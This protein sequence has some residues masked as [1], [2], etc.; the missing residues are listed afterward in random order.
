M[1]RGRRRSNQR[2]GEARVA[3]G[4]VEDGAAPVEKP[5][6]KTFEASLGSWTVHRNATC[7]R[8]EQLCAA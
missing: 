2:T 3:Y 4:N 8:L 1:K 6:E 7:G 5:S